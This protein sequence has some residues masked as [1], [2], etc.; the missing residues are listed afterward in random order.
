MRDIMLRKKSSALLQI[1]EDRTNQNS[2]DIFEIDYNKINIENERQLFEKQEQEKFE[3]QAKLQESI[4]KA[5][6][7]EERGM[8]VE[9]NR[10]YFK[11]YLSSDKGQFRDKVL[12]LLEKSIDFQRMQLK[13]KMEKYY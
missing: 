6:R 13:G 11:V 2:Q 10:I 7:L 9:A 8:Y 5:Q 1:F 4:E 12:Q 3:K